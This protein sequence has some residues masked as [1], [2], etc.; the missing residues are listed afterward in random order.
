MVLDEKPP[1]WLPVMYERLKHLIINVDAFREKVRIGHYSQIGGKGKRSKGIG[2]QPRGTK[3]VKDR[4]HNSGK[5]NK[6]T[7]TQGSNL[8][9]CSTIEMACKVK[10]T[11][12]HMEREHL[13]KENE[14]RAK[15]MKM[16]KKGNG[17]EVKP[18][19]ERGE[20]IKK[21]R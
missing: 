4:R 14:E 5:G 2:K 19:K 20:K 3:V 8:K 12:T 1:T 13:R 10:K 18:D 17:G 7:R 9:S 16:E 6:C 15:R 11:P 21:M